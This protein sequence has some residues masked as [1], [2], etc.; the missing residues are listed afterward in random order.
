MKFMATWKVAP[1]HQRVAA[2]RF[3]AGG[4]QPPEGMQILGRWHAPGSAMGFAPCETDDLVL[5]AAH[6]AEWGNLLE[7]NV[8][9]VIEDEAAGVALARGIEAGGGLSGADPS[10]C[11]PAGAVLRLAPRSRPSGTWWDDDCSVLEGERHIS[12]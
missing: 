1:E 7:L 8:I 10:R 6:L 2:R 3:I 11:S 12:R 5:V 9:P 4:A